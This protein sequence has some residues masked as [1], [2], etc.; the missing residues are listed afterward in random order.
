MENYNYTKSINLALHENMKLNS[1]S[2][3]IGLGINDPKR[4]F[5]TSIGL[6]E[7]FGEERCI[8]PP[9]SENALTGIALG[10]ALQSYSV[11]L[12]H[13]RFDFAL[14]SFDQLINSISKWSFMF[15]KEY[16]ISLLVR[17]I[18]GRGWGQGP[19]HSQSYH[20]F[21][22][23]LP[24]LQIYYPS[25]PSSAFATISKGM[26]SGKP[27]IMIEH[28]WLHNT[29]ELL[30]ISNID[31]DI[32]DKMKIIHHG[33]DIT[34]FTYGYMVP[35]A[36]KASQYLKSFDIKVELISMDNLSMKNIDTI[37]DSISKT[38]RLLIIEPYYMQ[39]SITTNICT[40]ILKKITNTNLDLSSL[41]VLSLPFEN[42]STSYFDTKDRYVTW[43]N[44]INKIADQLNQE[45][46]CPTPK[47]R[48]HDVP[49]D[50]FKGPF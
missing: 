28:R 49:G 44:I 5:G 24:G 7:A 35:E 6:V 15:N 48:P 45:I 30:D 34:I 8:E 47:E 10:L 17:L 11:C 26:N 27:T 23:S 3:C 33:D 1:R 42:E 39:C 37:I 14:L 4:I 9:T 31:I 38:H 41:E 46:P 36:F 40:E 43:V 2:V 50:W 13:Q 18:I 21:L 32:I 19:T 16:K 25:S 22:S 29:N 20:S 12:T